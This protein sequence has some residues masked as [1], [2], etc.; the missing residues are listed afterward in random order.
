MPDL[1][2]LQRDFA[3]ALQTRQ[4]LPDGYLPAAHQTRFAI[5]LNNVHHGLA[6]SLAAA[7]PVVR[8][9]VGEEFF[10][11]AAGLYVTENLPRSRSLTLYGADF[12][13]FLYRF[14]PARSLPYLADIA[15][16]ERAALEALHAPDDP[17]ASQA[18]LFALGDALSETPLALHPATRLVVSRHPVLAIHDAN[19][20][21]DTA[22]R[23]IEAT[24]QAVL[25]FRQDD[26]L[27]RQAVAPAD[28]ILL[29]RLKAGWSLSRIA[30]DCPAVHAGGGLVSRF[31]RLSLL[32]VF[33]RPP[34]D[35]HPLETRP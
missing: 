18:D 32:P 15:R 10:F 20:A 34:L 21:A 17:V 26:G 28:A 16:L 9:L 3:T 2:T 12:P 11:A 14:P 8:R 33:A 4:T 24:P 25:V 6:Q 27:C 5:Y 30:G 19:Q 13:R 35:I 31:Q 7:Y 29:R 23:A 22:T 1:S